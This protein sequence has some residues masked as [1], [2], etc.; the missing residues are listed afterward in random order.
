ML[1]FITEKIE[2]NRIVEQIQTL[3]RKDRDIEIIADFARVAELGIYD[4]SYLMK[5]ITIKLRHMFSDISECL[6][7]R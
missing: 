3:Q 5:G 2:I 4:C 1:G 6:A 7:E